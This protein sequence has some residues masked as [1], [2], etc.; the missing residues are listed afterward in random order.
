MTKNIHFPVIINGMVEATGQVICKHDLVR[1]SNNEYRS[2]DIMEVTCPYCK[3]LWF[4]HNKRKLTNIPKQGNILIH[5]TT[6]I[7]DNEWKSVCGSVDV[8][9]Y[10]ICSSNDLRDVNCIRCLQE[11]A[12]EEI[13]EIFSK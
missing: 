7:I 5:W 1:S 8:K 12:E 9:N 3:Y 11:L 10:H 2:H 6:K 13:N 4:K